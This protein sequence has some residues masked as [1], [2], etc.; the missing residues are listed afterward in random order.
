MRE[1]GSKAKLWIALPT[2]I[3]V[4]I[5]NVF[6]FFLFMVLYGHV[7][8]PGHEEQFYQDAAG[9]FGPIASIIGGI[10]LMY[11]AGRWIGKR[12]G[13]QLAVKAALLV[14]LIYFTVDVAIVAASGFLIGLLLMVVISFATKLAA[15][16]LGASHS[17]KT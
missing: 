17:Q 12:V 11:L 5:L 13:P 8:D 15:V 14:W 16:Y 6:L 3:V 7:I 9:R 4:G 10:P 2:A 1:I